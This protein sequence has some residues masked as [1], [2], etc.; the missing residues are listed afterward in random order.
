MKKIRIGVLMGGKSI[1]REVSFNS[2][3]T[4]CDHLD[5]H[6]YDIIPLFQSVRGSLYIL[7]WQFLHRGKISDFEHRLV[8][9][10]TSLIWDDLKQCVD[11]IFIAMHG[12]FAEDGRLQGM[13]ELLQ[14]PYLGSG[15]LASALGMNKS[16]QKELL[17]SHSIR[18]AR[19]I[20]VTVEQI[21]NWSHHEAAILAL[22][23]KKEISFPYIVKPCHEG[24]SLGV[25]I[26]TNN[27][28]LQEAVMYASTIAE[29]AQN[30]LIEEHIKGMEFS[31]VSL[32]DYKNKK[33]S[34]LTPTEVAYKSGK[35]IFDYEQ[36]YMP[37]QAIEFTPA[38]CSTENLEKIQQ[39]CVRVTEL[40]GMRTISR[41]D[42]FLTKDNQVIIIDPNSFSGLAPSSFVFREAAE[43]GMSHPE[44]IN[45]IIRASL[46]Y[47]GIQPEVEKYNEETT[48]MPENKIRVAVLMGGA[49]HERETSL[50][51][52]RNVV[53]KL[54]TEKYISVPLFVTKNLELYQINQRLLVRNSTAEIE[55]LLD[56]S[57]KVAWSQLPEIADFVFI[58]LHGG[59][60]ENGAV[61]GALE[62]LGMPYNGSGVLTSA[63]CMDKFKTNEFLKNKGF[64]IPTHLL[65]AKSEW[66]LDQ[67]T[68]LEKI[69]RDMP[70]PL[71]VKPHDDGCSVMVQKV[72]DE[73]HLIQSLSLIFDDKK[74]YALVEEY[75]SGMEL[76]VGVVGNTRI[77]ALPPSQAVTT[78]DILSIQEKF[79]PGAGENQTPAP[80][81]QV[82][83]AFIQS[84]VEQ[85]YHAVGC[86]GYARIDCFYQTAQQSKTGKERVIILEINTLPATTPA[87]CLFHQAA[88]VGISPRGLIDTI[89]QL[90]QEA[91]GKKN[92]ADLS[93]NSLPVNLSKDRQIEQP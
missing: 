64:D 65:V 31:C 82:T 93:F 43:Q 78:H 24:S 32:Y 1:E 10:A 49:S 36:K 60:G 71:I 85:V 25:R 11:F 39:T 4:V 23:E 47:Y 84:M 46:D 9:E 63:L 40:L 75:I 19:G 81:P 58:A 68:A 90:G 20:T 69:M 34:A 16:I 17:S 57:C 22:L 77:Q 26:V 45:H 52:G 8:N 62:M 6:Y 80:L 59:V 88:E 79:L 56:D 15:I 35:L 7:P 27:Q 55:Q 37:G 86:I 44:L 76:T 74:E 70:F 5:T 83:L 14:I 18:M 61:Q 67:T 50:D 2:G 89:I 92:N 66:L 41:I 33:F 30:V 48:F 73:A 3:R 42:G 38:R 91:H 53:Y 54:A 13:L 51:S 72:I 28:D 21:N 29:K 87:T 12:Q